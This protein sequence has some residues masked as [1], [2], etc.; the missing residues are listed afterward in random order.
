MKSKYII[1]LKNGITKEIY[2]KKH[3]KKYIAYDGEKEYDPVDPG[4]IV[5]FN[6]NQKVVQENLI[7]FDIDGLKILTYFNNWAAPKLTVEKG[8]KVKTNF[9]ANNLKVG[10]PLLIGFVIA[11]VVMM[12][13]LM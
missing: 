4:T 8:V 7:Y 2:L 5:E 11:M 12:I 1:T 10:L 13:L 9:I 6:G 3:G